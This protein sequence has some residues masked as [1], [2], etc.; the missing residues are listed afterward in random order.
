M[1]P[2]RGKWERLGPACD[3]WM[4]AMGMMDIVPRLRRDAYGKVKYTAVVAGAGGDP[5]R[6]QDFDWHRAKSTRCNYL[7]DSF[8]EA[9]LL[10]LVAFAVGVLEALWWRQ[11]WF[12][13]RSSVPQR[14]LAHQLCKAPL[15]C[16]LAWYKA[17]PGVR[18]A[19]YLSQLATGCADRLKL[20]WSRSYGSFEEFC[21]AE[22]A[23]LRIFRI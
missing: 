13:R 7:C 12:K 21:E 8:S 4:L 9:L 15:I 14:I 16:D 17:N 19:Q 23:A 2:Q 18:A 3:W 5:M 1:T 11:G 10:G 6:T 20:L 22:P